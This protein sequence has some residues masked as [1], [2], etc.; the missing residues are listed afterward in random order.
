LVVFFFPL[1]FWCLTCGFFG[2]WW[3]WLEPTKVG[4][5]SEPGA[6]HQ[7]RGAADQRHGAIA[8]VEAMWN[9]GG[10]QVDLIVGEEPPDSDERERLA[11][12]V[13]MG[14]RCGL[15]VLGGDGGVHDQ[16]ATILGHAQADG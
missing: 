11:H 9:S 7:D 6:W 2:F 4:Q 1:S 8:P 16:A 15:G 10:S 13:S 3:V 5:L 14:Q 12:E